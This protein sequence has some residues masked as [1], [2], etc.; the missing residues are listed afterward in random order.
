LVEPQPYFLRLSPLIFVFTLLILQLSLVSFSSSFSR[1]QQYY[2]GHSL[3]VISIK[4]Q[5]PIFIVASYSS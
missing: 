1:L 5:D 4:L 3:S 2:L